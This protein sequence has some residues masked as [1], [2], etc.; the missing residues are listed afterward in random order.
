MS[1]TALS[2]TDLGVTARGRRPL[3]GVNLEARRGRVTTLVGAS[4]AGKTTVFRPVFGT[5]PDALTVTAGRAWLAL[6]DEQLVSS[7]PPEAVERAAGR[8]R[9]DLLRVPPPD[10]RPLLGRFVSHVPQNPQSALDPLVPVRAIFADA[11]VAHCPGLRWRDAAARTEAE[12]ERVGL[13]PELAGQRAG[14]LSGGE[15]QRALVALAHLLEPAVVVYDEPTT[16]L[17]PKAKLALLKLIRSRVAA[18]TAAVI[19]THDLAAVRFLADD[20]SVLSGGAVVESGPAARVL[21][22]PR[23][24]ATRVLLAHDLCLDPRPAA[25]LQPANC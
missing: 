25:D 15:A 3:E 1:D 22:H 14:S 24:E 10:R 18:G 12:L 9:V 5:L 17:D 8:V 11:L 7:L 23:H 2:I 19:V 20:I 4:G 21:A 13:K 16:A 6:P